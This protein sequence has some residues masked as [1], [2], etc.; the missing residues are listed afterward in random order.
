MASEEI[1]EEIIG[2]GPPTEAQ[3]DDWIE[4]LQTCRH[5]PERALKQLCDLV[6]EYLMEESNVQP[7]SS[8]VTVC[9]DIHGQ[10]YD[11]MELFKTGGKL[12]E[13][14][15]VFM[16]DFV[17][18]GYYSLETFSLLLA[19]KARWPHKITLLRGNRMYRK[20]HKERGKKKKKEKKKKKKS[21]KK[22]EKLTKT[23]LPR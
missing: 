14:N 20:R 21:K 19:L 11:L 10:F 9:G 18:R 7:V 5:L 8:P 15:Y 12:P 3:L 17:D 2:N 23:C 13:T 1:V 22:T 6:V 16:G 4:T